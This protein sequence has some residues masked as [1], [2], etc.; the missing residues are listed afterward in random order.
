MIS[1]NYLEDGHLCKEI[2]YVH[3]KIKD[4]G[5]SIVIGSYVG[6]N[7]MKNIIM[8]KDNNEK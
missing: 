5:V 3:V 4:K 6:S 2:Y 1:I 7:C 8:K